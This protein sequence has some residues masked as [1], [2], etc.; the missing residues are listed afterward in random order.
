M[1]ACY[2]LTP[3][4]PQCG[5]GGFGVGFALPLPTSSLS[6]EAK[7]LA[8][9]NGRTR[10][11]NLFSKATKQ[12]GSQSLTS[13]LVRGSAEHLALRH[14]Q[15]R[16]CVSAGSAE[17]LALRRQTYSHPLAYQTS[18][19]SKA[20]KRQ[21]PEHARSEWRSV[22]QRPDDAP[23]TYGFTTESRRACW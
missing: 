11:R 19:F 21:N 17:H 7:C 6:F 4:P 1:R 13:E 16:A 14:E 10:R 9:P 18:V 15:W 8:D 12:L 22:G 2:P 3:P 20:T 5:G 23:A